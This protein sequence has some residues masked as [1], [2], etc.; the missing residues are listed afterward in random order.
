MPRQASTK[1]R[2]SVQEIAELNPAIVLKLRQSHSLDLELYE[3][4]EQHFRE[5]PRAMAG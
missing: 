5:Q 4:A 2:P 3:Y 1:R